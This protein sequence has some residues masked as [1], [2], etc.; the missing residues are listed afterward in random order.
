MQVNI[1]GKHGNL[2]GGRLTPLI[3]L[4]AGLDALFLSRKGATRNFQ[5]RRGK[6]PERMAPGGEG[7]EGA[8]VYGARFFRDPNPV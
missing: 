8:R 1:S 2:L 3:N 5:V 7:S 6:D 4:I